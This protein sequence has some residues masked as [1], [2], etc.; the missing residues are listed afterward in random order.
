MTAG[1]PLRVKISGEVNPL[2][3]PAATRRQF[4]NRTGKSE[5]IRRAALTNTQIDRRTRP[6]GIA[7]ARARWKAASDERPLRKAPTQKA[8]AYNQT[9]RMLRPVQQDVLS[10][11][12][13]L[14]CSFRQAE[15][16]VQSVSDGEGESFDVLFRKALDAVNSGKMFTRKAVA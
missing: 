8:T 16:A 10:A 3:I 13:N 5:T 9:T 1:D 12:M 15:D 14:G 7:S 2:N 11:L 6:V 4:S